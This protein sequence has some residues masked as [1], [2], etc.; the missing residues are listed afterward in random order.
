MDELKPGVSINTIELFASA[1]GKRVMKKKDRF[2]FIDYLFEH[3]TDHPLTSKKDVA[4]KLADDF[5]AIHPDLKVNENWIYRLFCAG[6][7]KDEEGKYGFKLVDCT[8]D[9]ACEKPTLLEKAFKRT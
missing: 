6:I 4:K 2:M 3:L 1:G 7:Y 8:V 9:E 5:R